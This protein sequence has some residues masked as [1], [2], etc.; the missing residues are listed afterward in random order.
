MAASSINLD[1]TDVQGLVASG[2]KRLRSADYLLFRIADARGAR[3][4]LAQLADQLTNAASPV[5][6]T[7]VNVGLTL[8]GL[9]HLGLAAEALATFPTEFVEGM[10]TPHRSRVLG[11]EGAN[12]PEHWR[13]GGGSDS[14]VDIVLMV[15]ATDGPTLAQLRR[16]LGVDSI[17]GLE[18]VAELHTSDLG[19]REHF[20][21]NDGISQPTILGLGR[22]ALAHDLIQPGEFV[23]GYPNEYGLIPPSPVV[24]GNADPNRILPAATDGSAARDLG[25]NGTYMVFRQMRQDVAGFWNYAGQQAVASG[26][27]LPEKLAAKI[28]GRW[29]SGAPLVMAPDTD[30]PELATFNDFGFHAA[31]PDGLRCPAGAH[32]RRTNPRDSLDPA[33]GTD[34][35]I[36]LV[37]RHRILR[38]G[39]E[40]GLPITS[41]ALGPRPP[42]SDDGQE[43]GLH[44]ICLC[45]NLVRQFEFVQGTW[46]ASPKFAGLY[47]DADPLMAVHGVSGASFNIPARPFRYRLRALPQFVTVVGG[48]YFFLPSIR[49][50]RYL[51]AIDS[52]RQQAST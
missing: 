26:Q 27:G 5:T 47:D 40:Y 44:F 14:S 11:D 20:G 2:Y 36:A 39:R 41:G 35:S 15:F 16:T 30:R 33:P 48:A 46:I 43:R 8:T 9:Q 24:A 50:V 17:V 34:R 23:L 37:K 49:A 3:D 6:A 12:A 4:W 7:G 1:F 29:P 22:E 19:S 13:W 32:I 25:K 10:A 21:F 42:L 38:R 45:A 28:V 18:K 52:K 31:D 51:G